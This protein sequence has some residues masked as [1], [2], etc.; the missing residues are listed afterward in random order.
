[1][2]KNKVL[3]VLLS[4]TLAFGIS[5]TALSFPTDA[6]AASTNKVEL[7][8]GDYSRN[9]EVE[10]LYHL[11]EKI[12]QTISYNQ[13]GYRGTLSQYSSRV[14]QAGILVTFK[15]NVTCTKAPCMM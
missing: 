15:G 4:T 8:A 12:P 7:L 10:I 14:A 5:F 2:K 6:N 1:M 11:G 3:S 9:V 13:N